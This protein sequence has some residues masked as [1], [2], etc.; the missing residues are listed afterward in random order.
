LQALELEEKKSTAFK[1]S[2]DYIAGLFDGEGTIGL[3]TYKT[4][5]S[6]HFQP[7]VGISN[8]DRRVIEIVKETLGF[9]RIY[10]QKKTDKKDVFTWYAHTVDEV[11]EFVRIFKDRSYVKREQ[12]QL[13]EEVLQYIP[14]S[15]N[16]VLYRPLDTMLRL[17]EYVKRFRELNFRTRR[18]S[19]IDLNHLKELI[20]KLYTG[21]AQRTRYTAHLNPETFLKLHWE[22]GKSIRA[23]AKLLGVHHST[24]IRFVRKH[25]LP[26]RKREVKR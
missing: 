15:H 10:A 20:T 19:N 5:N 11:A 8:T 17:V 2:L 3:G 21:N 18:S 26:Y 9:G 22:E 12:L 7:F 6:I 14:N 16:K 4:G 13:M 24:L 1:L 25:N 23:I